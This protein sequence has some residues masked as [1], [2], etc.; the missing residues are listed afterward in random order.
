MYEQKQKQ[1]QNKLCVLN[2]TNI[3][4]ICLR[5]YQLKRETRF[6]VSNFMNDKNE[7]VFVDRDKLH[8]GKKIV[9]CYAQ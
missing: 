7:V 2:E 8:G 6:I 5:K 1:K 9:C 3:M 4:S